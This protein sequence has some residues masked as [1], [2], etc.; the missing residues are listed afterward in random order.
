MTQAEKHKQTNAN[1]RAAVSTTRITVSIA[2]PPSKKAQA[3]AIV[4]A[5]LRQAAGVPDSP[6]REPKAA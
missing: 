6:Q 2:L 1:L 4:N 5:L 3:D